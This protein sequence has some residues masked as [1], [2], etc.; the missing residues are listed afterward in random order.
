MIFGTFN[1]LEKYM[2]ITKCFEL[3]QVDSDVPWQVVKDSYYHLAKKFHPD[4]NP[5]NEDAEIKF[6]EI[7]QAFQLLQVH[8]NGQA[9]KNLVKGDNDAKKWWIFFRKIHENPRLKILKDRIVEYLKKLDGNIFHLNIHKSIQVPAATAK[10]GGSIFMKSSVE[11]FE[12]KIPPG[13][14]TRLSLNIPGKG[15]PSLFGKRRG[16]FILDL[17]IS[18]SGMITPKK[19]SFS[20]EMVIERSNL[21]QVMTLNSSEG[22]IKYVLPRSTIDGQEFHLKSNV[23]S[24]HTHILTVRLTDKIL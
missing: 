18:K 8:F 17:N 22:P 4:L 5:S 21:G 20:Y 14:W 3:L 13:D 24:R 1:V 15:Q 12:V 7:N 6:K 9:G 16:D 19:F 10:K 2:Q 23:D 11:K